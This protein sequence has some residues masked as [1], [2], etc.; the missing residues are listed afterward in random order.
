M[1]SPKN[2]K[3]RQRSQQRG[4]GGD[5]QRQGR[6]AGAARIE[7]KDESTAEERGE[8]DGPQA[9]RRGK[10]SRDDGKKGN[11]SEDGLKMVPGPEGARVR[12]GRGWRTRG[13]R[14]G[15]LP[16]LDRDTV[17]PAERG[18]ETDGLGQAKSCP[19]GVFT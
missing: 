10:I 17:D 4:I 13:R 6:D 2:G 8:I 1:N 18:K 7:R 15:R 19:V 16:L 9:G 14:R 12:P 3:K 11:A 5:A